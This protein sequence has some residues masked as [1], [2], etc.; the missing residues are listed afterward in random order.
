VLEAVEKQSDAAS[1]RAHEVANEMNRS[2][3]LLKD[4][5]T[6]FVEN[7]ST[8]LARTMGMFEESMTDM[9]RKMVADLKAAAEGGSAVDLKQFSR[10]QQAL[11]DMTQ[12]LNKATQAA[13][14][15]AEGA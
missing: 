14:R 8:G 12:A 11:A 5:Y 3:Q 2:G 13:S 1:D 9:T 15:M 4:S 6:S 10:V 7:V